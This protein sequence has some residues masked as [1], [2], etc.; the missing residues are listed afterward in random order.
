MQMHFTTLYGM[1]D[2]RRFDCNRV[3]IRFYGH[4]KVLQCTKIT[5]ARNLD[6]D[7]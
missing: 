4:A 2:T 3:D 7:Q 1:G 6:D 5:R